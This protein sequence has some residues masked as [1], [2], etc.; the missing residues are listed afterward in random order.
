ME[1]VATKGGEAQTDGKEHSC[2]AILP[3][4]AI[5]S[6]T[7]WP[8]KQDGMKYPPGEM[9]TKTV[10]EQ[11][12]SVSARGLLPEIP[13]RAPKVISLETSSV[14]APFRKEPLF[15]GRAG[16]RLLPD[17]ENNSVKVS[18]G[19]SPENN[20]R[21]LFM[22]VSILKGGGNRKPQALEKEHEK[23]EKGHQ[24]NKEKDTENRRRETKLQSKTEEE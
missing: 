14:G 15:M 9:I 8:K 22:S 10:R 16:G 20:S 24:K 12:D 18:L 13:A 17:P 23:K 7:H 21:I 4:M 19:K 1:T 2:T 3:T 6:L 11:F 5:Q